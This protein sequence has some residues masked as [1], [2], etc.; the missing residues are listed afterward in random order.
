MKNSLTK[1][2]IDY[3]TYKKEWVT[4]GELNKLAIKND[5]KH[6]EVADTISQL[7]NISNIGYLIKQGF[8]YYPSKEIDE[9]NQKA[10]DDF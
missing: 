1:R 6:R 8:F 5:Y 4:E 10:L 3:L 2:M 7:K 9:L